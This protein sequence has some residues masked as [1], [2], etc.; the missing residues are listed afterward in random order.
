MNSWGGYPTPSR[1]RAADGIKARS[2]Q[3]AIGAT[4]WSRRFTDVLESLGVGGRLA[5]GK[6]YARRGQVLNLHVEA[7][8]VSA[9]VQGSR[10]RPYRVSLSVRAYGKTEWAQITAALASN[11]SYLASLLNAQMPEDIEDVFAQAGLP[12]FPQ[13]DRELVM[14]C[15]CPDWEVPCKHLAAVMYLLAEAFDDD[16]FLIMQWR[17]RG[18]EEL[19]NNLRAARG[20]ADATATSSGGSLSE[21]LD[22][23]FSMRAPMAGLAT[24]SLQ[25]GVILDRIAPVSLSV[26]GVSLMDA[27]RPA[28]S[29]ADPDGRKEAG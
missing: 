3:G 26:R 13:S 9:A 12:L 2:R 7:G 25:P 24:S 8:R 17:G 5:R 20:G 28:Y 1:P 16:P 18:R 23:F 10:A 19:L 6:N 15:S 21:Q 22:V 29:L 4:W 27:L 11:A 14:D